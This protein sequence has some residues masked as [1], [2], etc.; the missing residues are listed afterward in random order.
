MAYIYPAEVY[1]FRA[2]AHAISAAAG[3]S[4]RI[5]SSLAFN[6]LT[7][8]IGMPTVLWNFFGCCLAG[9]A[10]TTLLPEVK[11]RDPDAIDE[12]ERREAALAAAR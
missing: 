3:K 11:G 9:A 5:I 10:L 6:S 8:K 1:A 2:S 12:E 7:K 4:G